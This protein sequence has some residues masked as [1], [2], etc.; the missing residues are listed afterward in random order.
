MPPW[1]ACKAADIFALAK[2]YKHICSASPT[3]K[4]LEEVEAQVSKIKSQGL[5]FFL[6]N[7]CGWSSKV[8]PTGK[9]PHHQAD[10]QFLIRPPHRPSS[11]D[12]T[13]WD[14]FIFLCVNA[15]PNCKT[16]VFFLAEETFFRA[17]GYKSTNTYV[18]FSFANKKVSWKRSDPRFKIFQ[19]RVIC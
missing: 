9:M 17:K 10:P 3:K 11:I 6:L 14:K 16:R 12:R 2:G 18:K 1:N 13:W 4:W 5:D 7:I 15:R 8:G 19:A